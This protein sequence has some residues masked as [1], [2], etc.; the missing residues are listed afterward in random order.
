MTLPK[1]LNLIFGLLILV[2]VVAGFTSINHPIILKWFA[3]SARHIGKPMKATVY[4]NGELSEGI[5]VFYVEKYWGSNKK[6]KNYLIS[7]REYDSTSVLRFLNIN[8]KEKW[9]GR[10]VGNS[11]NDYDFIWGHLFQSETGGHFS[12]F[13]DEMKGFSFDPQLSIADKQIKFN[14]PANKLKFDSITIVLQ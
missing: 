7:I 14:V 2:A 8:L 10:P 6:A 13:Q 3:G 9:I 4:K 1:F 12:P 11:K 5:K